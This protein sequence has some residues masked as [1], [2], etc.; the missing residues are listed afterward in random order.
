MLTVT[1][2]PK[3]I[4]KP[5]ETLLECGCV[6]SAMIHFSCSTEDDHLKPDIKEKI[7]SGRQASIAAYLVRLVDF[8]SIIIKNALFFIRIDLSTIC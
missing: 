8:I 2:P 3:T 4:L 6:P 7:V 5:E 1:A